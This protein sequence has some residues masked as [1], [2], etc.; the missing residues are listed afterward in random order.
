LAKQWWAG[1]VRAQADKGEPPLSDFSG[2][3]AALSACVRP[4]NGSRIAYAEL[5]S[6]SQGERTMCEYVAVFDLL[7]SR[8]FE[9]LPDSFLVHLFLSGLR[10]DI[11]PI[12]ALQQPTDLAAAVSFAIAFADVQIEIVGHCQGN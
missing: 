9:P 3:S 6:L 7:R 11:Q 5:L 8:T 12:L 10:A 4:L 2:F 1:Y